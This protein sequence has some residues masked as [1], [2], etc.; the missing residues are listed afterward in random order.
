MTPAAEVTTER[1][2]IV[3]VSG[4]KDAA[5]LTL[6]ETDNDTDYY[7]VDAR[8]TFA[9]ARKIGQALLEVA[10]LPTFEEGDVV[11]VV[12]PEIRYPGVD[13]LR[14]G[15]LAFVANPM[16]DNDGELCLQTVDHVGYAR[17][18]GLE[19]VHRE[20]EPEPREFK[21]GDCVRII[22]NTS[23]LHSHGIG[24][25]GEVVGFSTSLS[26]GYYGSPDVRIAGLHQTVGRDDLELVEPAR[27]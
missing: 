20:P 14:A 4:D 25:V 6:T 2:R 12:D 13:G 3:K 18:A 10:P 16:P 24:A 23:P 21:V 22:G 8:L 27:G 5:F 11:R 1:A 9:E 15:A 19:L 7:R 26:E 17:P